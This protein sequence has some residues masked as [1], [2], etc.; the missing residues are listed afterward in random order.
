MNSSIAMLFRAIQSSVEKVFVECLW[1]ARL[2]SLI[3]QPVVTLVAV[4][5]TKPI[6][7]IMEVYKEGHRDFGENYV[8]ELIT[9]AS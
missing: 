3:R 6:E 1:K 9:K 2:V 5:K 7:D 8:D 4:S